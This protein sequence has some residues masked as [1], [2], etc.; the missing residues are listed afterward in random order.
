[1]HINAPDLPVVQRWGCVAVADRQ[2][3]AMRIT[4]TLAL[5][6]YG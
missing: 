3:G 5:T 6:K 4:L 1:M 2:P